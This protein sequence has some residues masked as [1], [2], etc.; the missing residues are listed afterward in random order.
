MTKLCDKSIIPAI[1]LI[2]KHFIKPGFS[3]IYDRNPILSQ[4]IRGVI[5]KL[6]TITDQFHFYPFLIKFLKDLFL[7]H[8][9]NFFMK[10]ICL[11]RVNQVS[12]HLIHVNISSYQLYMIYMHH[13]TVIHLVMSE[14]YF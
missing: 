13:L 11:I 9:L 5:S 1:S 12:D 7:I 10:I 3:L 8:Y 2:Y 4:F 14:V 6:L